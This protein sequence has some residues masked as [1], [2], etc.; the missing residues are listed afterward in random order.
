M[1]LSL[2]EG[3]G[4]CAM[5]IK[6]IDDQHKLSEGPLDWLKGKSAAYKG[7]G[8]RNSVAKD[9]YSK[10]MQSVGMDKTLANNPQAL[11]QF[12][13][14]AARN[15]AN[16]P[17]PTDMSPGGV[18]E[19]ITTVTGQSLAAA[20]RDNPEADSWGA[21]HD[22]S[23]GGPDTAGDPVKTKFPGLTVQA[24]HKDPKLEPLLD[25]NGQKYSI[26]PETGRWVNEIGVPANDNLQSTF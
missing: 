20:M 23:R 18:S 7:A 22:A 13:Q 10:W 9:L 17:A 3:L 25:L 8:T 5:K 26:N 24:G 19:Y 4:K 2:P 21:R 15:V 16:V 14:K 12:M 1:P 11:Q 6:E